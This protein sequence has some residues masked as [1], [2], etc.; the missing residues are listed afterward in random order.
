M[1]WLQALPS[2][3][4]LSFSVFLCVAGRAYW[5]ERGGGGGVGAKSYDERES[6]VHDKSFNTLWKKALKKVS[7]VFPTQKLQVLPIFQ[8]TF[9]L[10]LV[11]WKALP[12]T[13]KR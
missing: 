1:I 7:F 3:T 4:C 9:P 11:K 10:L 12:M 5:K 8:R 13:F 2:A 6:L